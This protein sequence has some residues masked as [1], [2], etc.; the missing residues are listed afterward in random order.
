MNNRKFLGNAALVFGLLAA[1][2]SFAEDTNTTEQARVKSQEGPTYQNLV[3]EK[4]A[5]QTAE[6]RSAMKSLYTEK[7]P[8]NAN[9]EA[10]KRHQERTQTRQGGSTQEYGTM[11]MSRDGSA[12]GGQYGGSQGG[13]SQGAGRGGRGGR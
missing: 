5:K 12:A 9:S 1:G 6:Q 11:S 13:G 3:K 10:G 7:I 2:S 4:E 8:E